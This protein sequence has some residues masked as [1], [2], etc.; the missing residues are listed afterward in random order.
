MPPAGPGG[1]EPKLEA[2]CRRAAFGL[3]GPV[4]SAPV[5]IFNKRNAVVGW[6]VVKIGKRAAKK[7]AQDAVPDARTGGAVAGA[8]AALGG[9]LLFWRHTRRSGG[10]DE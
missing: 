3:S 4:A 6:L 9:V 8:L 7:K 10:G 2:A 5:S 1:H